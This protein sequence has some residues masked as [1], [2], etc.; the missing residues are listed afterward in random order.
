[1]EL[2]LNNQ[3]V[4]EVCVD[5]VDS[6]VAAQRGGAAWCICRSGQPDAPTLATAAFDRL[7]LQHR[8]WMTH[9]EV[10]RTKKSHT[11]QSLARVFPSNGG[12]ILR[13]ER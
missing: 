2:N 6:A 7:A 3:I 9:P 11:G 8:Y 5:A 10:A 13:P 1:M 4:L 12:N